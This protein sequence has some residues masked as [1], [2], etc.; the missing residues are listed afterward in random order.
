[1]ISWH[2]VNALFDHNKTSRTA[3]MPISFYNDTLQD[4]R[5]S[6]NQ[7]KSAIKLGHDEL[8][9]LNMLGN[10]E[11]LLIFASITITL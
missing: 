2:K 4:R 5:T 8:L 7:A 3:S 11:K 6:P 1:M 9:T 10:S